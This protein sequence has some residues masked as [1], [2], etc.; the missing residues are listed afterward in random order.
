MSIEDRGNGLIFIEV[1]N[2][3]ELVDNVHKKTLEGYTLS[4]KN[5]HI[6]SGMFG[7]F[8]CGMNAGVPLS[9]K[10]TKPSEVVT[11]EEQTIPED[12]VDEELQTTTV[13]NTPTPVKLGR[14]RRSKG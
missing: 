7:H 13:E 6:A 2:I 12:N 8:S 5:E 9:A 4:N 1:G 14:N 3:A 10:E 11:P